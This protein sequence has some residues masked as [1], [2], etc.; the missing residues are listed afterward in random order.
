MPVSESNIERQMGVNFVCVNHSQNSENSYAYLGFFQLRWES[1]API[2]RSWS[3]ES[4]ATQTS[5]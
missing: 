3:V 1:F 2:F 4:E 5:V